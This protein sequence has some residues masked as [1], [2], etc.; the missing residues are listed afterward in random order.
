MQER[1]ACFNWS[2][3]RLICLNRDSW[4]IRLYIHLSAC[5]WMDFFAMIGEKG[6]AKM[7]VKDDYLIEIVD[8]EKH[9]HYKNRRP[10]WVKIYH[11]LLDKKSWRDL[12]GTASK[13]LIDLWLTA[14][15]D[16][17]TGKIADAS[18][19]LAWRYRIDSNLLAQFNEDLQELENQGFIKLAIN[20]LASCYQPASKV[21]AQSRVEKSRVEKRE[22]QLRATRTRVMQEP[23]QDD[24]LLLVVEKYRQRKK[25]AT[26]PTERIDMLEELCKKFGHEKVLL[27]IDGLFEWTDHLTPATLK[28]QLEGKPGSA[29]DSPKPTKSKNYQKECDEWNDKKESQNE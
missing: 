7:E 5:F 12:S 11:S 1:F 22:K 10:T 26:L 29:Q 6:E 24:K 21:L 16:G 25:T 23:C 17:F 4:N 9:Q 8:W 19:L 2:G 3:N 20:T 15:E 13:L 27:A 14:C 18:T 28:R